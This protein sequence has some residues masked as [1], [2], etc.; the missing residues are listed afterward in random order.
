M[1]N[2]LTC[3]FCLYGFALSA[4][5]RVTIS[6]YVKDRS[7]GE[8]LIGANVY[9]KD[10]PSIGTYSNTYGFYSLTI[11][12]GS[13][14]MVAT[15]LGYQNAEVVMNAR[16]NTS[17]NFELSEG[18]QIEE[19]IVRAEEVDKNVESTEMGTVDL[20]TEQ[21]KRLPAL[22]GE[23]DVLKTIQLLPGVSS[24]GEGNAGF[25]VRGGGP[26]QNL[27]LLDEAVVYNTGHM[28]GF[29]SVF[30]ADAIKNTTVIKGGAPAKYGGRVSSVLDIQMKEGND[31]NY[32]AQGGI[33]LISSRLTLEGPLVRE[34]SSFIIS[35][36]RTYAL[37]LAQPI[38]D[39]TS[40]A[41]TNYYFYDLNAK[42]NY[43]FSDKDR[44]YASAYFG[45]DVLKFNS[46]ERDF[47]VRLPYGNA[48]T[49]F[50][51]NHLFS[52]KHF[53]NLSVMYNEYDFTFRGSQE[54]FEFEAFSGVKDW[55][56]KLDLEYYPNT[57]HV[58]KYG[59]SAIHHRMTPNIVSATNGETDFETD[60]RPKYGIESGAYF[61][62][63]FRVGD[64]LKINA[65]LR[66]SRFTQFGPYTSKITGDNFGDWES[67]ISYDGWEPRIGAKLTIKPGTSIKAN[68]SQ[69]YQ[70]IHLVSNSSS[71]L[72]ADVWVPSSE[73]VKPQ[74]STQYALGFFR[75]F[76]DNMFESSVEVYYK[77]L[78]NQI[79]YRDSY[80]NNVSTEVEDDF[81]FGKGAAYGVELFF[82]KS[83]GDLTGW[84]GYTLSRT[85]RS[86][87]EIE[88]GRTYPA[89]YDRTH[90]LSLVMS[91]KLS[92]KW[93]LSGV[94]VYGTGRAFTPIES[95]YF[96]EN[97]LNVE[98]GPRN[99]ARFDPYHR[100]DLSATYTPKPDS[101]KNFSSSWT[102]SI[103]NAYNRQ[104]TFFTYTTF[105]SDALSG[106][107][108]ANAY[109]VS[110]FPIIPSVT[111][112]FSWN[113]K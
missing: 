72:P 100:I 99:S 52:E 54:E 7:S 9:I 22:L 20:S 25:Y 98:Y 56:V 40:F 32:A 46:N 5:E 74:K 84:I 101:R 59:V 47:G 60:F 113:Q 109:K 49:T 87:D 30:N 44:I 16:E 36:R 41:G 42:V 55:T 66:Y 85:E 88:D 6:G 45:R 35:A 111:W 43:S 27:V 29:F 107:A 106:S 34:R 57:D 108:S 90:D 69:A 102:F 79:D 17:L 18:V 37:D 110:L 80:V 91:Y 65:G 53:S 82:K 95:L 112:N 3:L 71:T 31:K 50:R 68:F 26:D 10:A 1:R 86:F 64:R 67:V 8:T 12:T 4:Q 63:E 21:I 39:K 15:Y 14:T 83:K 13:Y 97:K 33:G 11:D 61:Q 104:N 105:E 19:V 28:L 24:V 77:D 93:D 38:I 73:I 76:M 78:E 48:T 62:D 51:W 23:V 70:Y 92:E 2:I 89:V 94:F 58:I 75:N 96:I 81:V 103:Y